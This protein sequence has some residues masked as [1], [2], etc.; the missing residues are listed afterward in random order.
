MGHHEQW[1]RHSN[2]TKVYFLILAEGMRKWGLEE[3]GGHIY[4]LIQQIF[5]EFLFCARTVLSARH[6]T[7]KK[8]EI[9]T[10]TALKL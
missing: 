7:W 3:M 2:M 1:L 5:I 9:L 10:T 4:T 8:K 6:T